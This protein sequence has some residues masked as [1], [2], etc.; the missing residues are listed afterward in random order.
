MIGDG[1][2][3]VDPFPENFSNGSPALIGD[4][5]VPVDPFPENFSNGSPTSIGNGQTPV[6]PF[7]ENFSDGSPASSGDG[8]TPVD[9]FSQNIEAPLL[10]TAPETES[11]EFTP[12]IIE[13]Q[14][15]SQENVRQQMARPRPPQVDGDILLDSR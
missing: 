9:P 12:Q 15:E 4:G 11:P 8:Q 1:Q 2:I 6:N 13:I 14:T 10:N 7:P 5:Q 3:P